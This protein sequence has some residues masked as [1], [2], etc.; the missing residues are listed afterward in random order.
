MYAPTSKRLPGESPLTLAA[1]VYRVACGP[2]LHAEAPLS[3]PD[4][5]SGLAGMRSGHAAHW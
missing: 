4:T 5:W 1:G 2:L 3:A